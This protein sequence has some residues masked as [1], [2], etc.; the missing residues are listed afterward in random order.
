MNGGQVGEGSAM[1]LRTVPA[2]TRSRIRV[3]WAASL[4]TAVRTTWTPRPGSVAGGVVAVT[5]VPPP[6]SRLLTPRPTRSGRRLLSPRRPDRPRR[7]AGTAHL[8]P[9]A[10]R[11]PSTSAPPHR[12]ARHP[13]GRAGKSAPKTDSQAAFVPATPYDES[14]EK[15]RFS[16]FSRFGPG[17]RT[18]PAGFQYDKHFRPLPVGLILRPGENSASSSRATTPSAGPCRW[19]AT[20]P[21]T[22]PDN[23]GRHLLH[24]GGRYDSYLQPPGLL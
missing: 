16:R 15:G 20:S 2:A 17:P 3:S 19:P 23:H 6:R 12:P 7:P 22:T 24:T 10:T 18:L 11:A 13:A 5:K 21:R 8:E 4:R 9:A 1:S 14:K